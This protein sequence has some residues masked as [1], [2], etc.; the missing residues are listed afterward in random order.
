MFVLREIED[1]LPIKPHLLQIEAEAIEYE[2]TKK[3]INKILPNVGLC[4]KL[5]DLLFVGEGIIYPG[6]PSPYFKVIFRM[7]I[8][9]PFVGEIIVGKVKDL[10]AEGI[11]VTLDF[12]EDI[13]I[14]SSLFLQP[15]T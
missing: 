4:I 12:F 11:Q 9:R 1:T 14:P 10:S 7:V 3:Y 2:I 13:L 15:S 6:E 5:F 8:F